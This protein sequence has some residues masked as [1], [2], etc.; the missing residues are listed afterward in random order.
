MID[1]NKKF[2]DL[3]NKISGIIEENKND[4]KIINKYINKL[5]MIEKKFVEKFY[6]YDKSIIKF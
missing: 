1:Y 3:N 5:D 2:K 4:N 6:Y